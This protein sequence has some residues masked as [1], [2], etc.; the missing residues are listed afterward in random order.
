MET[1]KDDLSYRQVQMQTTKLLIENK[2]LKKDLV[3]YKTE[4]QKLKEYIMA[5]T[6]WKHNKVTNIDYL[7]TISAE[8]LGKMIVCPDTYD[9]QVKCMYRG[10]GNMYDDSCYKCK[11]KWLREMKGG[12]HLINR[13]G[14]GK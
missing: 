7:R 4:N 13:E 2:D 14:E 9:P 8:F 1:I 5:T 10:K 12:L 11:V 3:K 6:D